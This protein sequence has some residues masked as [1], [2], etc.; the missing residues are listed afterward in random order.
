MSDW[1]EAQDDARYEAMADAE[2]RDTV[3]TLPRNALSRQRQTGQRTGTVDQ[4]WELRISAGECPRGSCSGVLDDGC[5]MLCGWSL[6]EH[7]MRTRVAVRE[8]AADHL[9]TYPG[10]LRLDEYAPADVDE[11][12]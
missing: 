9:V 10:A 3:E 4:L 6:T 11:A 5:C 12:A 2:F 1:R 8:Q 7:R